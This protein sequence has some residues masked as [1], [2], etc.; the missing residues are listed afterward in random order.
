MST[1]DKF[2]FPRDE[3][4]SVAAFQHHFE[5]TWER[6]VPH[7]KEKAHVIAWPSRQIELIFELIFSP[8]VPS[9]CISA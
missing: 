3:P 7:Q 4:T 6:T 5:Q 1:V 9:R 2:G 8:A